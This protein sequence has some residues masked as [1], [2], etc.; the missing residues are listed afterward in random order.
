MSLGL[1]WYGRKQSWV[2]PIKVIERLENMQQL[3]NQLIVRWDK[4]YSIQKVDFDT[5]WKVQK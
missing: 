4:Y 3:I 5:L 2:I 1:R